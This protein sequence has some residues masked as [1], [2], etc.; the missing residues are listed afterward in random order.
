MEQQSGDLEGK[1]C[2]CEMCEQLARWYYLLNLPIE[3]D[4]DEFFRGQA[5]I[6][7][8]I[9]ALEAKREKSHVAFPNSR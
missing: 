3:G 8:D 4:V 6:V 7:K 5:E 1:L 2:K 9:E